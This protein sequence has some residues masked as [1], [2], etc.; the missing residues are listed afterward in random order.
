MEQH[1]K[2]EL[3]T[4]APERVVEAAL[5]T[6]SERLGVEEFDGAVQ[7][8]LDEGGL[9]GTNSLAQIE[10]LVEEASERHDEVA[11]FLRVAMA[12]PDFVPP[13]TLQSTL[14]EV[15]SKQSAISS[16]LYVIGVVLVSLYLI[17]KTGGVTKHDRKIRMKTLK[18]GSTEIEIDEKIEKINPFSPLLKLIKTLIG[19]EQPGQDD[20]QSGE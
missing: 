13:A 14:A 1:L 7:R 19:G 20:A 9:G 10:E 8:L 2:T 18:D 6:L 12:D 15:G 4:L 17:H 3:E 16:E 5:M 11:R